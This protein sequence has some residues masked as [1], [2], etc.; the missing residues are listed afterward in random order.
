MTEEMK[1]NKRTGLLKIILFLIIGIF[2]VSLAIYCAIIGR[3]LYII[4]KITNNPRKAHRV[5][6]LPGKI[7][8]DKL[9]PKEWSKYSIGYAEFSYPSITALDLSV[10]GGTGIIIKSPSFTIGVMPP[11]DYDKETSELKKSFSEYAKVPPYNRLFALKHGVLRWELI[12]EAT[13]LPTLLEVIKMGNQDFAF[14]FSNLSLK[15]IYPY[16]HA[17]VKVLR[18][19]S[20]ECLIRIGRSG[21][22]YNTAQVTLVDIN[23]KNGISIVFT[24]K[25]NNGKNALEM[26]IP[27]LQTFKFIVDS[28]HAEEEI[29]KLIL[30]ACRRTT[31]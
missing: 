10:S 5:G 20:S 6:V 8:V 30:G 13:T 27:I 1:K 18:T 22:D 19:G 21:N 12:I 23:N 31:S 2:I 15:S 26:L 28:V 29:K 11:F 4:K 3:R 9:E 16:G 14:Q 7:T 25:N 24:G 17:G